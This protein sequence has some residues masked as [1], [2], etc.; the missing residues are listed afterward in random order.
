MLS[1]LPLLFTVAADCSVLAG[2]L[3]RAAAVY[4]SAQ[5]KIRAGNAREGIADLRALLRTAP[6]LVQAQWAIA[7]AE[8]ARGNYVW[9]YMAYKRYTYAAAVHA[10]DRAEAVARLK[11]LEKKEPAFAAYAQAEEAALT[12]SWPKAVELARL[13]IDRK[14]KF[15]L[16]H[17]LLGVALA[18]SGQDDAAV[19]AY[20]EYIALE[21]DAPEKVELEEFIA[22]YRHAGTQ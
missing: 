1:L 19:D 7:R 2:D 16:A 6:W 18:S 13:A 17:R 4:A 14:P 12:K 9:A 10:E 20:A 5:E 8:H 22:D 15:P 11:E 21:P 3:E